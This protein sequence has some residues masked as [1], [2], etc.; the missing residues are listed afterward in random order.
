MA[1][2]V[3]YYSGHTNCN[4]SLEV[5]SWQGLLLFP[6][7]FSPAIGSSTPPSQLKGF[8]VGLICTFIKSYLM[9]MIVRLN[10]FLAALTSLP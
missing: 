2:N 5:N 10:C 3:N 7:H 4:M 1:T 9:N 8:S 6:Y